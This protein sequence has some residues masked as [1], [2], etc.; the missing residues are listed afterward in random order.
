M[1]K[2]TSDGGKLNNCS[3]LK[4]IHNVYFVIRFTNCE[5]E[6]LKAEKIENYYCFGKTPVL[7]RK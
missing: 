5:A 1:Y 7:P 3:V 6:K 2:A 4:V